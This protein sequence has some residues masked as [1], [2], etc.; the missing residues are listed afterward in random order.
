MWYLRH[1]RKPR[2]T[3]VGNNRRGTREFTWRL[4]F[5]CSNMSNTNTS[6]TYTKKGKRTLRNERSC[7]LFS[8][9]F[10]RAGLVSLPFLFDPP[11]DSDK[12]AH[13]PLRIF[14]ARPDSSQICGIHNWTDFFIKLEEVR[15]S[16]GQ[17]RSVLP[18]AARIVIFPGSFIV[19]LQVT[20]AA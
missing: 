16:Q 18:E 17:F 19:S 20:Q 8:A 1:R 14:M 4:F 3:R 5:C 7:T 15:L 2:V 10:P 6:Q 9:H 11:T 12:K 13:I